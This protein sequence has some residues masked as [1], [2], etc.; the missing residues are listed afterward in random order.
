MVIQFII[1]IGSSEVKMQL[2]E[3]LSVIDTIKSEMSSG[4][5]HGLREAM[6]NVFDFP[7]VQVSP[8]LD[9]A[10]WL[11]AAL[12]QLQHV[13]QRFTQDCCL[14]TGSGFTH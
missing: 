7:T 13:Q 2:T 5:S 8:G 10:V 3:R 4:D 14:D 9:A 11:T 6:E 12:Y 1:K